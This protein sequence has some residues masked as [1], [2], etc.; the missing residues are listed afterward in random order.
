MPRFLERSSPLPRFS[1][2]RVKKT[3]AEKSP[4]RDDSDG[5]KI[6]YVKVMT[7]PSVGLSGN[8]FECSGVYPSLDQFLRW[9]EIDKKTF[10]IS[11]Y[12]K[13]GDTKYTVLRSDDDFPE[14]LDESKVKFSKPTSKP[15]AM[16]KTNKKVSKKPAGKKSS[17]KQSSLEDFFK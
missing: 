17:P 16:K 13:E 10:F 14:A 7:M 11:R 12:R 6:E 2:K 15:K 8:G 4:S 1:L 3:S 9:C 5:V